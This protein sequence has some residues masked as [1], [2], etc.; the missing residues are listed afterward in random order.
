MISNKYALFQVSAVLLL[1]SG[2]FGPSK[3]IV[4]AEKVI[5]EAL[6]D[7]QSAQ[8][9]EMK[10]YSATNYVCGTVNAKNKLGGY[11]GNKKFVVSLDMQKHAFDPDRDTPSPPRSPTYTSFESA[12]QYLNETTA[13][14]AKIQKIL[15]EG[16]AFDNLIATKCTDTPKQVEEALEKS[17]KKSNPKIVNFVYQPGTT[18]VEPEFLGDNLSHIA[19]QVAKLTRSKGASETTD[20]YKK[21]MSVLSFD[22]SPSDYEKLYSVKI[23]TAPYDVQKSTGY[24]AD[25]GILSINYKNSLNDGLCEDKNIPKY[26]S[27][28]PLVCLVGN[29]VSLSISNKNG[30][31][32][33]YLKGRSNMFEKGNYDLIDEFPFPRE[34][35]S[36]IQTIPDSSSTFNLNVSTLLVGKIVK[37]QKNPSHA[38]V[39]EPLLSSEKTHAHAVNIGAIPFDLKYIVHYNT[40]TGEVLATRE[41][42]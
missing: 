16:E 28:H 8:F 7:G 14:Q 5:R 19:E 15:S 38:W 13:W 22:P 42:K 35:L 1:I 25:K 29:K 11:V 31:L 4:T 21:R 27:E 33:K 40:K 17:A 24:N 32:K 12:L 36:T 23:T 3:E 10:F 26:S 2:C 30:L 41:L 34:S 18:K 9:G 20:E 6:I 37:D 39:E